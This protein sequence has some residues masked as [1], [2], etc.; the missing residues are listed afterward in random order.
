VINDFYQNNFNPWLNLHRPCMF[1]ISQVSPKGKVIKVYKHSE[2]KTP[3]EAL[4]LLQQQGLATLKTS[5]TLADLLTRAAQQT[6][7]EAAQ[8]M[9]REKVKLFANFSLQKRRA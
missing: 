5:T 8:E 6:D 7:L 3:L 9:Q 1:A 4:S 2:V